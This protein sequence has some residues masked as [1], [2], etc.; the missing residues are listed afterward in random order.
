MLAIFHHPETTRRLADQVVE[1][2]PPP[3]VEEL[4][5]EVA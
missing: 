3:A 4:L 2:A 1:L 5:E